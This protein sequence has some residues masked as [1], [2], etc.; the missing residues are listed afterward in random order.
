MKK[1]SELKGPAFS[2]GKTIG[3]LSLH[4]FR[5]FLAQ[6]FKF[7]RRLQMS[8]L[9]PEHFFRAGKEYSAVS[10]GELYRKR[11]VQC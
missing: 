8:K 2:S 9:Y 10:L 3:Y 11:Y 6:P 4:L 1:D 5:G 7:T